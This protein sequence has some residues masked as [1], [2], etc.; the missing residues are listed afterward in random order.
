MR[1]LFLISSFM[2][3]LAGCQSTHIADLT[4]PRPSTISG[5]VQSIDDDGFVLKDMTGS[6]AVEVEDISLEDKISVG[7]KV[8][9]KGVLDEDD[10]IGKTD[11]V[12]EEF[13]AYV[14]IL[15]NGEEISLV[16]YD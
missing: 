1:K 3:F 9:V 12:I 5:Y 8:T 14:V 6:I 13:D 4:L 11:I 15:Q 16:P 10:S 2:I 7:D